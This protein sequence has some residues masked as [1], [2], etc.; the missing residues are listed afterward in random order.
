VKKRLESKDK[1]SVLAFLSKLNH[2]NCNRISDS[3]RRIRDQVCTEF[4]RRS[5]F[6]AVACGWL[7]T[8]EANCVY[9]HGYCLD[10]DFSY[11]ICRSYSTKVVEIRR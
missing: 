8:C 10:S 5:L 6:S 11:N 2:F 1:A 9:D 7:R 3:I 4:R